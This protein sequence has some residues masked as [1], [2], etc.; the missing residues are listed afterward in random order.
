MC[1]YV[2]VCAC[3]CVCV[4]SLIRPPISHIWG[5]LLQATHVDGSYIKL[6]SKFPLDGVLQKKLVAKVEKVEFICF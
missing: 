3:A 2:C 4:C 6:L 5:W 1:V